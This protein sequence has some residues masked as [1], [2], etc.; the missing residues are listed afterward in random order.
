METSPGEMAQ[1]VCCCFFEGFYPVGC[2][3][4]GGVGGEGLPSSFSHPL[5]FHAEVI[6]NFFFFVHLVI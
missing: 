6:W 4:G 5:M 1:E 2:V 3:G